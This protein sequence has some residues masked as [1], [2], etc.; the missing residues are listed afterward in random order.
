MG[1]TTHLIIMLIIIIGLVGAIYFYLNKE[2]EK[3]EK[4]SRFT[5]EDLLKKTL[6]HINDY[7][8]ANVTGIGLT[9]QAI[10]KQENQRRSIARSVRTCNSGNAGSRVVVKD[11]IYSWLVELGINDENADNIIPFDQP[12]MMTGRQLFETMLFL[13]DKNDDMAFLRLHQKYNFIK[14][15]EEANGSVHYEISEEDIR[16]M[17]YA[18]RYYLDI[19]DKLGILT[20]M[21][22]A[23]TIGLGVIDT[24]NYQR[25]CIEEIQIGLSG[26]PNQVYNYKQEIQAEEKKQKI[27]YSKDAIHILIH[28]V[29]IW[30]SF[31][32]FESESEMQRVLRNLI[33]DSSAGE[34]TNSSPWASVEASD[35]R[36]ITVSR[37]TMSDS[38]NGFVRKF[39]TLMVTDLDS[40]YYEKP[41]SADVNDIIKAI[42]RSGSHVG[43][44]GEMAAGKTS[45]L[46]S[47][48]Q[49][50]RSDLSIRVVESG[51]FEVN[52]RKCLPGRNS[53]A[54]RVTET[55]SEEDALALIRKTTGQIL[56]VGEIN[57][58]A[59]ANLTMNVSKFSRQT[60]FT[61]HYVSTDDM[62][63][64]FV[65]AKLCVGSFSNEKLAE[66]DAVKALGFDIHINMVRGT[67][68]VQ[69]INEVVPE[70][71]LERYYDH[72]NVTEQNALVK[73]TESIREL[74]KQMGKTRTYSI[75]KIVEFDDDSNCYILRN[76]PSEACYE[77]ARGYMTPEQYRAFCE[78]FDRLSAAPEGKLYTTKAAIT[79]TENAEIAL[80]DDSQNIVTLEEFFAETN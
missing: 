74:R 46:R 58:L 47:V 56:C 35:G 51:S 53:M 41:G 5:Y 80:Q 9:K 34:L 76:K 61:A 65:A 79:P 70:F 78:L 42:V 57:S 55:I 67:R 71:D 26:L 31:L 11:L 14:P 16:K 6:E 13:N 37:P 23:D 60:F 4:Q 40:L 59:M 54:I 49:E 7:T 75:R 44:T 30:L 19:K 29:N 43:I 66:M 12:G 3:L 2:A 18:E 36:R 45:M 73:T 17:F 1:I 10:R 25:G 69:Y 15:V 21:L 20:Q 68:Y 24:L 50:T 72:E 38:W 33:L 39:D 22:F 27:L 52:V 8:S 63:Q 64:D 48:L 32:G 62:V 28:G 77:K